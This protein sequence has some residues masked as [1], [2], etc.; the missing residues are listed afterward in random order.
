MQHAP[1]QVLLL[2]L[3][4]WTYAVQFAQEFYHMLLRIHRRV[5]LTCLVPNDRHRD[6]ALPRF[7]SHVHRECPFPLCLFGHPSVVLNLFHVLIAL[8][9][10]YRKDPA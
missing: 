7:T 5:A 3:V 6:I 10:E 9:P 2:L 4:Q 1:T 8:M